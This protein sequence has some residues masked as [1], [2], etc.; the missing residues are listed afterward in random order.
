[1]TRIDESQIIDREA[2]IEV[3]NSMLRCETPRRVLV[4]SDK[5]G[6]GKSDVLRKLRYLC[7]F[8]HNIPVALI[9]LR[10]FQS[11][12]DVFKLVLELQEALRSGGA[13]FPAFDALNSARAFQDTNYFLEQMRSV[14]ALVDARG[15]HVDGQARVAGVMF[16]VEHAGNVQLP[17]WNEQAEIEAQS[18]CREAFL[19]D[20][21]EYASERPVVLLFDT[22]DIDGGEELR[23]WLFLELISRRLLRDWQHHR[24]IVVLAGQQVAE[25]LKAR[26]RPKESGCIE[27]IATLSRWEL[28]HVRE[29]LTVHGFR[30]LS[31]EDVKTIHEMLGRGKTLS[32][33]LIVAQ[34]FTAEVHA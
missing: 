24:L 20:L 7:E 19:V 14:R 34:A 16:N 2:E 13:A 32:C 23:R 26:L 18:L 21:L 9:D 22:I 17:P 11:R 15:A 3:F 33:A 30:D 31:D 1:M 28:H 6:M 27:P 12:P 5:S 4:V 29:F 10:V 25:M 8:T